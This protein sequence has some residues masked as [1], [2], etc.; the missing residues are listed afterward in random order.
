M[1]GSSVKSDVAGAV[2]YDNTGTQSTT[3]NAQDA[4]TEKV[5][6][7]ASSTSKSIP[8]YS[9]TSGKVLLNNSSSVINAS[10][11]L[12]LGTTS[13]TAKVHA[14]GTTAQDIRA[15]ATNAIS[16]ASV[17]L[18]SGATNTFQWSY[19]SNLIPSGLR[20]LFNGFTRMLVNTSGWVNIAGSTSPSKPLTVTGG[21]YLAGGIQFVHTKIQN[22]DYDISLDDF[23]VYIDPGS[24]MSQVVLPNTSDAFGQAFVIIDATNTGSPLNP[25][26]I[27]RYD[28]A[29]TID[30]VAA[31]GVIN[32]AGQRVRIVC[33]DK[34]EWYTW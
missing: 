26:N 24:G 4:I 21:T 13:P 3:T 12:G 5:I 29:D 6:G 34:N 14:S 16:A 18:K 33:R 11:F 8:T 20:L 9:N 17:S 32:T 31:D 15:D 19:T 2:A 25:V 28:G 22:T 10:G 1:F 27:V 23:F 30:G 7:P